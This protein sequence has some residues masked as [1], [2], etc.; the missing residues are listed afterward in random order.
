MI[1][2]QP[3]LL[4]AANV[5]TEVRDGNPSALALME[6]HYS[7]VR[8]G[9]G[10]R[11]DRFVGPGERIVLLTA[12]ARALFVW[13]RFR[14]KDDQRGVNCAVFRNEGSTLSSDLIRAAM[15]LAWHRWPGERF[16]TYVNP[17]KIRSPNP[18]YCF[19]R[20]GWRRCGITK[21]RRLLVLEFVP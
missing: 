11:H 18:G 17:R 1:A 4:P 15:D 8:Y 3:F 12:D 14:S 21:S 6:R 16:Y 7:R 13:R 9:D 20:A 10:R 2:A 5:W 19:L